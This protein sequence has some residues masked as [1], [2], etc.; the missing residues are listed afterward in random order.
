MI[1]YRKKPAHNADIHAKNYWVIEKM[2]N[3]Y[4]MSGLL[5]IC[6]RY[7]K[8]GEVRT[9]ILNLVDSLGA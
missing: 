2:I 4:G 8:P 5:K 9:K 3:L 6:V 7:L 1:S